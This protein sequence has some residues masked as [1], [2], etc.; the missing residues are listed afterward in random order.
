MTKRCWNDIGTAPKN[1]AEIFLL[2]SSVAVRAFWCAEQKRWVLSSPMSREY[3]DD[4]L[5][6]APTRLG[7]SQDDVI[8]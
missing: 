1:G 4:A 8:E 7:P 6:W 2:I 5:A 3:A